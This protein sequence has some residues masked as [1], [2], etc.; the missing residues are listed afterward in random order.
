MNV[1]RMTE[2][3]STV[4][5]YIDLA[6]HLM[7]IPGYL[8]SY[9]GFALMTVA[10]EGPGQGAVVEIGSYLGLSTCWLA[11][12]CKRS[13]RGKVYAV[14]HFR[15]SPEH[16][17][18]EICEDARIASVGTTLHAF[19]EHVAAHQLEE[20][21]EPIVAGSEEAA[22][23]WDGRPIRL[24]FIDADHSYE[25]SKGDFDAWARY[26]E[27]GGLIAFHDIGTW[28]GVTQFY[29]ELLT[30]RSAEF[31]QVIAC[32]ELRFVIKKRRA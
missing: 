11:T 16:Q 18:G 32:R 7:E 6:G 4:Y 15:G 20:W 3:L 14:D 30:N 22:A 24:L 25:A 23:Q 21:V 29:I 12:G 1:E 19:K 5:E 28:P 10:E 8:N 26:V 9:H 27:P 13:G 17:V 31:E 2:R